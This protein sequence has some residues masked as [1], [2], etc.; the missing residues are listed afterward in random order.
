[1]NW[2]TFEA[3]A[4]AMKPFRH[5]TLPSVFPDDLVENL[6]ALPFDP[7]RI[8]DT[9]GRRETN[10]STRTFFGAEQQARYPACRAVAGL[11]QRPEVVGA[12]ETLT[13][14]DLHGSYLRTEYCLD[15]NGFWLEPHTD[16]GAKR[17]TLLVY[18]SRGGESESWGTDLLDGEQALVTRVPCRFNTGVLFIPAADTWH[19]FP[20]RPING[21]RRTII[22]NYVG[23]EWRARHE[24]CD[25]DRPVP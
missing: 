8:E 4:C 24:L 18:L 19:S 16:I 13:G 12:I 25:P 14:A 1:M 23:P 6:A 15:G 3:A 22:I 11:F 7:P 20:K 2:S 17:L 9:G 21:I 10:N 5:W